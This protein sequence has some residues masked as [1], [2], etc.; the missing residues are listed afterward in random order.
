VELAIFQEDAMKWTQKAKKRKT[1]FTSNNAPNRNFQL[2]K[3]V[4]QGSQGS[5]KSGRWVARPPQ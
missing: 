5:Q 3:K 2:V 4:D 1:A